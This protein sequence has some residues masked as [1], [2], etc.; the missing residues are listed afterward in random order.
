MKLVSVNVISPT[1]ICFCGDIIMEIT[2]IK[3]FP[4][5]EGR[6]KA[7][8]TMV[9]DN[10]FIIRDLKI[11]ESDKGLFVS[12]PSRRK[13]DGSFKDIVHPLNSE[14]RKMIE[15]KVIEEYKKV[16]EQG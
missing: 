12:M 1:N 11:I 10:C 15:D 14:T 7:Y 3:V 9:F 2:E 4:A 5:K 13:K 8:A 6:L 16:A